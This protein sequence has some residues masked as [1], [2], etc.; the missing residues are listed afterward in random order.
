MRRNRTQLQSRREIWK[1]VLHIAMLCA[2]RHV[3]SYAE[4]KL[5]V[6]AQPASTFGAK[7]DQARLG[8]H[9][10]T[11]T[12]SI[13]CGYGSGMSRGIASCWKTAP[14]NRE[15]GWPTTRNMPDGVN[16]DSE[17]DRCSTVA[18][19]ARAPAPVALLAEPAGPVVFLVGAFQLKL[20]LAAGLAFVGLTVHRR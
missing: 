6:P 7:I 20:Q 12:S 13:L 17:P 14:S 5:L 8:R 15:G 19:L 18:E 2:D 9:A 11:G 4:G 10:L 1:A 3:T 16:A